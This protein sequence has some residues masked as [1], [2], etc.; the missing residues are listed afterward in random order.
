MTASITREAALRLGMAAR[1]LGGV[2]LNGFVQAVGDKIGLPLTETRLSTVTV[3]DLREILA[4]NHAEEDCK[5]GVEPDTLKKVVRL[6]WGEDS[7]FSELPP[8]DDYVEGDMPGSIRVACASNTGEVLDGHFGSCERFL[9][10]QLTPGESRLIAIRSTLEA[11]YAEDRNAA[12]ASLIADC[13]VLC[14]QSIGGPAAAKVVRAGG[15]P[16]KVPHPEAA[17]AV[18]GRLQT[19]LHHPPPWLAKVMGVKAASL[20]KF[21]TT[22]D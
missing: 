20:E 19:A 11:D 9:I 6:L 3:T 10:Y 8:V 17:R 14:I 13:N 4:G 5:V 18:I 1:E 21:A 15:H 16:V 7:A 2:S 22:A 12:R